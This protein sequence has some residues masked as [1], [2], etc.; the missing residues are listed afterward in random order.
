MCLSYVLFLFIWLSRL[1]S[2]NN[3]KVHI[4][5]FIFLLWTLATANTIIYADLYSNLYG[6]MNIG[7]VRMWF[8]FPLILVCSFLASNY[9]KISFKILVIFYI[10]A[11]ASFVYQFMFGPIEW[12]ADYSERA[13]GVR[14]ASLAGS[15][16]AYGINVGIAALA[17][18]AFY[19]RK[20]AIFITII[21]LVGCFISLQKA[22]F[23][24][25]VMAWM[26]ASWFGWMPMVGLIYGIF[27]FISGMIILLISSNVDALPYINNFIGFLISDSDLTSDVSL[28]NSV[29]E[30]LW[31]LPLESLKFYELYKLSL[32]AGA[33]GGSGVFGYPDIPM[34]HNGFVE[35]IQVFGIIPGG[36][37][38]CMLTY[39][40]LYSL[41]VIWIRNSKFIAL[42]F[43]SSAFVIWF[44]NYLFSG[45]G[46]FHPIGAA[47]LWL[48]FFSFN[49]R[50]L[51]SNK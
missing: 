49:T 11:S 43:I 22:S 19:G 16:T 40:F 39:R 34:A 8:S 6:G 27:I 14:Y 51:K 45:G 28:I 50:N 10:L 41:K 35:I 7:L 15:L 24:N 48:L 33:Y 2:T 18:F 46:L 1:A 36:I 9:I 4:I 47:I 29:Y 13:G 5:L 12:F 20:M 30:R 23:V 31:L 44:V 21:L 3:S 25:I 17:A 26:F 37:L 38:I 42:N 32:G